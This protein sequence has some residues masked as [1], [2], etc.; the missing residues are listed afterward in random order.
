M[1]PALP[2]RAPAAVGVALVASLLLIPAVLASAG[3]AAAAPPASRIASDAS[4]VGPVGTAFGS[5]ASQ[6]RCDVNGDGLPD[7]AV[8]TYATF[9]AT[10]GATAAYVLLGAGADAGGGAGA[11]D[12]GGEVDDRG[13]VRIID[14]SDNMMGGVDVRCAGDVN[15][16]GFDDLVVVAQAS[17]AYIVMGSADFAEVRLDDLGDRGSAVRGSITRGN[18]IGDVDG[19]GLDEVAV[20]DTAGVVTILHAEALP[21]D[22][23]LGDVGGQ[24]ISGE[25]IDLVS[26]SRA[27]DMNG[28]GRDDL[29]V[30]AASWRAPGSDRFATGAVW[31]LTDVRRGVTV[32]SGPVPGFRI[33]GPPRGY[34]LLGTSTVGVGD[35]DA[36]GYD[37]LLIGG[38]SDD[39]RS[40]SAVVVTGGPDGADVRT[41]PDV[42]DGPAVRDAVSQRS[43][44]W[45]INGIASGDHFGHAVG[46]VPMRGWS[47]LLIGGMDGSPDGA[48]AGAGYALALDSRALVAGRA[49]ASA[50]GV[51]ETG[52][53]VDDGL[54]EGGADGLVLIPG[55]RAGQRL[56]RAFADLTRDPSGARA[57]FAVGAP[58]LFSGDVLPSVR[59]LELEMPDVVDPEPGVD[60]DADA[61]A[62]SGAEAQADAASGADAA[63]GTGAGAEAD[64]GAGTGGD[65]RAG[66]AR[67]DGGAGARA[68]GAEAHPDRSSGAALSEAGGPAQAGMILLAAALLA[69]GSAGLL[70]SRRRALRSGARGGTAVD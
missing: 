5:T 29:A 62:A 7:L 65:A 23:A 10:P 70:V 50:S 28:D 67:A 68:G 31:V 32:G 12:A 54:V 52:G 9:D 42:A 27:G 24:R 36:D 35:I 17:A 47:L 14:A 4:I 44:G 61:D 69:V 48:R 59:L 30:G 63:A 37:D 58:A 16:D 43:R 41:D 39:P 15:G 33:D 66:A 34:D 25:G 8:G 26:V 22:G 51:I 53:L 1:T 21:A 13:P 49:G 64:A 60:A 45:W 20:T 3:P 2:S 46:A 11:G 55:E 40:G 56:G 57:S 18:G 19:D 6:V 38:E